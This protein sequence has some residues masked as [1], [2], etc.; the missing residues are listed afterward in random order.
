M[1]R[2]VVTWSAAV[3]AALA[4]V[5]SGCGSGSETSS[6]PA[7]S[8]E[9]TSS[10]ASETS[11]STAPPST[12]RISPREQAPAGPAPT[13]AD[14]IKEN[15]IE[16]SPVKR[17]DP[18]APQIDLPLPEGWEDAGADKPEWAYSAI[19]YTG[20]EAAEYSPSIVALLSKLVGDVDPQAVLDAAAG[21]ASNLPGWEPMN[22]G[23][24]TTLGDYPAFQLGG[25]WVQDGV[26]KM[27]AQKTVVIPGGDGSWYVL[28]LNADSLE[29]QL[30]VL[31]PA[32]LAIDDETV[33][34]PR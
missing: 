26:T 29:S 13:I 20:P 4:L 3:V 2:S 23:K 9:T 34:T 19:I 11:T 17:G 12:A 10:P 24:M 6:S 30:D 32:T 31:G 8:P 7:S 5:V 27:A 1:K 18:G 22:E 25:T 16:E 14:Y 28:Q 33:I 15:G 21:E